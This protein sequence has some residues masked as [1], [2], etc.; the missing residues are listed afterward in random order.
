MAS[1]SRACHL[2]GGSAL[3]A[4]V[5]R[6]QH[7]FR[8]QEGFLTG[9]GMVTQNASIDFLA[10]QGV[11]MECSLVTPTCFGNITG[12][13]WVLRAFLAIY[14]LRQIPCL[15]FGE[16]VGLHFAMRSIVK[17]KRFVF[18]FL[19]SFL[20]SGSAAAQVVL[21]APVAEDAGQAMGYYL[22]QTA[23]IKNLVK[24]HPDLQREALVA[25][26]SFQRKFGRSIK[27]IDARMEE[28]L[29]DDW[30]RIKRDMLK[31]PKVQ[32]VV[33][34]T[35]TRHESQLFFREVTERSKGDIQS[36]ILET[37]LIFDPLYEKHPKREMLDGYRQT[38]HSDGTGKAMGVKYRLDFPKSWEI[39]EG[40]RPHIHVIAT[41]E[42]G[43]GL[44]SFLVDIREINLEGGGP[45]TFEEVEA[46]V[47]NGSVRELL[48]ENTVYL[49]SGTL[50]IEKLPGYWVCFDMTMVRG[51][52]EEI[53]FR[54]LAFYVFYKDRQLGFMGM[55][56]PSKLEVNDAAS[57]FPKY[58]PVFDNIFTSLVMPEV[59]LH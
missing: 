14:V 57:R 36:P 37:L 35:L 2:V 9:I 31:N 41:S 17:M 44:E 1:N 10:V 26:A 21:S 22:A 59:W 51:R 30:D 43:R 39:K 16:C 56:G 19:A 48:P 29:K 11:F 23:A 50:K 25:E 13:A 34:Q 47:K 53:T 7:A 49:D 6:T 12:V 27:N 15:L 52:S 58:E 5:T 20:F 38:F 45:I 32:S 24:L 55:V 40:K 8:L 54:V 33:N 3:P 28:L 4:E 18:T 42:L 46:T